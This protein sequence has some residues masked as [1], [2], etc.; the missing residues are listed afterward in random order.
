MCIGDGRYFDL[1]SPNQ[2]R[3]GVCV[4]GS[5]R[6]FVVSCSTVYDRRGAS[7]RQCSVFSYA[8]TMLTLHK[9]IYAFKTRLHMSTSG[10]GDKVIA[11][12]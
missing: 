8:I 4:C 10:S 1:L 2:S 7:R 3:K 9:T 12:V 5:F 11:C 6:Y